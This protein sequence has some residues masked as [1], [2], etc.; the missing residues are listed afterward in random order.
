M[1][2][3][4]GIRLGVQLAGRQIAF[5]SQMIKAVGLTA[6]AMHQAQARLQRQGSRQAPLMLALSRHFNAAAARAGL[7]QAAAR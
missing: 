5:Y 1:T 4:A 2:L 3:L 6:A 7:A